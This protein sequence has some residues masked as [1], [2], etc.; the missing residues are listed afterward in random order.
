MTE[1][2]IN[3]WKANANAYPRK[4]ILTPAQ[5]QGYVESRRKGIGGT[6]VNVNEH[7][8]VP[9]ELDESTPGV[10]VAADGSELTLP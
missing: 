6:S 4:F 2:V 7:M 10:M 5:H 8:G 9:V 3:H 1:G